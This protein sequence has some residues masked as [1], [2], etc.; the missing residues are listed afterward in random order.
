[1]LPPESRTS[2]P[3][4][5]SLWPLASRNSSRSCWPE[6]DWRA[7]T[8]RSPVDAA[9]TRNQSSSPGGMARRGTLRLITVPRS[10][11]GAGFGPD[12]VSRVVRQ[13][14]TDV[15]PQVIIVLAVRVRELAPVGVEGLV[16][17]A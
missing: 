5:N 12:G 13:G 16:G 3:L 4:A 15:V 11:A 10:V 8:I 1:M 7:E 14:Q 6:S 2:V 9:C 17:D